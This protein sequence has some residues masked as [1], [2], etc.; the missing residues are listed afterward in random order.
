MPGPSMAMVVLVALVVVQLAENIGLSLLWQSMFSGVVKLVIVGA[1]PDGLAV[2]TGALPFVVGA[3][4]PPPLCP[5]PVWPPPA[6]WPPL[7]PAAPASPAA[8]EV[9]DVLWSALVA[10]A[11]CAVV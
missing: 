6:L 8:V 7:P 11:F 5:P 4:P 2:V 3:W 10:A 1:G 9:L